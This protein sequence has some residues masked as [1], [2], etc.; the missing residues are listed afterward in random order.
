M[1][2]LHIFF[3]K[4]S[5]SF[6]ISSLSKITELHFIDIENNK[7]DFCIEIPSYPELIPIQKKS[8][9]YDKFYIFKNKNNA[10]LR[11]SMFKQIATGKPKIGLIKD[12]QG[13]YFEE[14]YELPE[15]IE[16]I[17]KETGIF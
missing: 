4:D 11:I 13:K 10:A 12:K 2:Q 14:A 7:F 9:E 3:N 1:N 6:R 5:K 15:W 17:L 16:L 8:L